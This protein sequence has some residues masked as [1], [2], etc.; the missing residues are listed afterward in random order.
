MAIVVGGSENPAGPFKVLGEPLQRKEIGMISI[1]PYLL[2][3]VRHIFILE[4][5]NFVMFF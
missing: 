1:P 2:M 4:I 5:L 3:M